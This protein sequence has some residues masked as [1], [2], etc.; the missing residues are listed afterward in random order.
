MDIKRISKEEAWQLRHKVMWPEKDMEYVKLDD[1][2]AGLHFGLVE[3]E[4]LISVVSLFIKSEEAQF[5]KFATLETYQNRGY[6]T[7]LLNVM[8]EEAIQAGVKRIYCNARRHKA[9]F[10]AKFGFQGTETTFSK[11]GKDYIVMERYI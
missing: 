6:G 3:G 5:R 2:D 8:L 1:D 9:P 4:Q 7:R 10:Y 11:D